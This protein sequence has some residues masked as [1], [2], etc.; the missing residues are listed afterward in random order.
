M[1]VDKLIKILQKM[2]RTCRVRFK[3]FGSDQDLW[4]DV[5]WVR[6]EKGEGVKISYKGPEEPSEWQ[7]VV[8]AN[9]G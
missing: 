8:E 9:N 6:Y 3:D 1:T 5:D 2:P 4:L 7:Y